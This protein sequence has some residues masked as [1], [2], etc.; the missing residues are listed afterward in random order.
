MKIT[1]IK[2]K[3]V[4]R[5]AENLILFAEQ[6]QEVIKLE[7]DYGYVFT[8]TSESDVEALTNYLTNYFNV[9]NLKE[10]I[11]TIMKK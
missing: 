2:K 3:S 10:L 4:E 8:I 11:E 5:L 1:K 9:D 7:N 6:E